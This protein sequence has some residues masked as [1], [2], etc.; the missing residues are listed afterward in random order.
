MKNV[1]S[2][3]LSNARGAIFGIDARI[4]IAI[5]AALS[6]TAGYYALG[7]IEQ[8]RNASIMKELAAVEN[9]MIQMQTDMGIFYQQSIAESNGRDDFQ[10]LWNSNYINSRFQRLWNGPYINEETTNHSILGTY[11]ITYYR[12]DM[13][14]CEN[15]GDCH[16][17]IAISETPTKI[18]NYINDYVDGNVGESPE[19]IKT[20]H[21]SG[22]IRAISLIEPRT[23]LYKA[24]SRKTRR[25]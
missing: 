1:Y 10:A 8:I 11:Y 15:K 3:F 13:S 20:A 14:P 16:A 17:F 22:K 25:Y 5:F 24:V 9:A 12:N 21:L 6:V 23:L 18:W 7:G 4:A 19:S 2:K